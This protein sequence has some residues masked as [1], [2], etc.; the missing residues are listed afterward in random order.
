M[1]FRSKRCGDR[2]D[3]SVLLPAVHTSISGAL[4]HIQDVVQAQD[5]TYIRSS[6]LHLVRCMRSRRLGLGH[7]HI[8]GPTSLNP[9]DSHACGARVGEDL[10]KQI[11]FP[12]VEEVDQYLLA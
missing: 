10:N 9:Q 11:E 12:R 8:N 7:K 6:R 3:A 5:D 2:F 1:L 4:A